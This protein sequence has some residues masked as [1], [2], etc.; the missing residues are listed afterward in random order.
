VKQI[1]K[2][3][4]SQ[5]EVVLKQ[6]IYKEFQPDDFSGFTIFSLKYFFVSLPILEASPIPLIFLKDRTARTMKITAKA[7]MIVATKRN[8]IQPARPI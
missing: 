2:Q 7:I 5:L 1:L 4:Q 3:N 8:E 6:L